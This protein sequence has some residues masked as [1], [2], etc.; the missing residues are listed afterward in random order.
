RW[1]HHA[2][3]NNITFRLLHL[4]L[5]RVTRV[6]SRAGTAD[7]GNAGQHAS[8]T[9]D[10]SV[11]QGSDSVRPGLQRG[12]DGFQALLKLVRWLVGEADREDRGAVA[13]PGSLG[14]QS[15]LPREAGVEVAGIR[16][17]EDVRVELHTAERSRLRAQ[18]PQLPGVR[19]DPPFD[20]SAG[21]CHECA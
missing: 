9:P 8:R 18:P 13:E 12:A 1:G 14:D 19:F 17:G 2:E 21:A 3:G 4:F 20:G 10:P 6:T 11:T 15:L 5:S 7:A 16:R